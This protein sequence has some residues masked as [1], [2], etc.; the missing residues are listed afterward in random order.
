MG[1]PDLAP[2]RSRPRDGGPG[3]DPR[4]QAWWCGGAASAGR[5]TKQHHGGERAGPLGGSVTPCPCHLRAPG[6]HGQGAHPPPSAPLGSGGSS[7]GGCLHT[8]GP[9]DTGPL[10]EGS[11]QGDG[12]A[13]GGARGHQG[14][15][16]GA[17]APAEGECLSSQPPEH[18]QTPHS[19][20][21]SRRGT[22]TKALHLSTDEK[23]HVSRDT[24]EA[25]TGRTHA[26]GLDHLRLPE[27]ICQEPGRAPC[28]PT[29]GP[30]PLVSTQPRSRLAVA[31]GWR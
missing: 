24:F 8:C 5:V 28:V 9:Q 18:A 14:P 11:Q 19:Q 30:R 27:R 26:P 23:V 15:G 7:R 4:K 29:A 2:L 17:G 13:Q 3:R 1:A 16:A 12:G 10:R 25:G 6:G 21:T 31:C 22:V 20:E